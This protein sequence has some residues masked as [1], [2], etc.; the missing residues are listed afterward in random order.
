MTTLHLCNG[1]CQH[2]AHTSQALCNKRHRADQQTYY[3]H[4]KF[5][6]PTVTAAQKWV[7]AC[8]FEHDETPAH[9]S[10]PEA[11][12]HHEDQ[13]HHPEVFG[14]HH[15]QECPCVEH[16][17]QPAFLVSGAPGALQAN[18]CGHCQHACMHNPTHPQQTLTCKHTT[19]RPVLVSLEAGP[20]PTRLVALHAGHGP[21]KARGWGPAVA[22]MPAHAHTCPVLVGD[23]VENMQ[24]Q[25]RALMTT[26]QQ[27]TWANH[28]PP[29]AGH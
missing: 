9:I 7:N 1:H 12:R 10:C 3:T 21:C 8:C 15:G 13:A 23:N 18:P 2:L 27:W 5:A 14:G 26:V 17:R 22:A 11:G 20:H 19:L 28:W 25:C 16:K 29:A 4:D 6:P 24:V